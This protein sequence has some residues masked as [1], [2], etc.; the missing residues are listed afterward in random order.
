MPNHQR[1]QRGGV[2]ALILALALPI[3]ARKNV[4][5]DSIL[6]S[7]PFILADSATHTYYMTGTGGQLWTSTN[8]QTWDGPKHLID[9]DTASW[10][11]KR[12]AIWAAELHH[13][14]GKYYCLATITNNG[15]TIDEVRG[16]RIPRR[17]THI[18]E[19][20][21]PGGPYRTASATPILPA[22]WA[23]LDGTLW[24][25]TDD[26]PYMVFCH[27]WLQA[28]F[29][30][31]EKIRLDASLR[32]SIGTSHLMFSA[33]DSPWSHD[34]KTGGPNVVTDGPFLFR[35]QSGRLGMIWSSWID[36]V[37]TQGVAYS[38]SGTLDG[39]W[40]HDEKPVT[41]EGYG[42]GM[43]FR[44]WKGRLLMA[45]HSHQ[46][47]GGRTVRHPHYFLMDDEDKL[48]TLAHFVP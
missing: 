5:T 37:Y 43:L 32:N 24:V 42:H 39:P 2:V 31:M 21:T 33:A 46:V 29:G 34:E 14:N 20:D 27:E 6:L 12:P 9:I 38:K 11:G 8:L 19:S 7:D 48:M 22:N 13:Y 40:I 47:V 25:D 30:T 44:D 10:M 35:T 41:P 23:T 26:K 28:G 45:I 3:A 36:G 1:L 16:Q 17:A 15:T 4:L 18:F